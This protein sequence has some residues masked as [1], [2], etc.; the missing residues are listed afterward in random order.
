MHLIFFTYSLVEGII[1][2]N[3]CLFLKIIYDSSLPT[4][5]KYIPLIVPYF[6]ICI[7]KVGPVAVLGW[8]W[9]QNCVSHTNQF[10]DADT[11]E[12]QIKSE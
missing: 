6:N 8:K 10:N 7:M 2:H 3:C 4:H 9:R 5:C 1:K 12:G 11:H